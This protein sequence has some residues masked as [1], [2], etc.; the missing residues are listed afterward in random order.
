MKK[1][2]ILIFVAILV[3]LL[4]LVSV[5]CNRDKTPPVENNVSREICAFYVGETENFAVSIEVKNA[6][7]QEGDTAKESF[8]PDFEI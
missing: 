8:I 7:I 5:S 6:F 4:A 1:K 2:L 3:A